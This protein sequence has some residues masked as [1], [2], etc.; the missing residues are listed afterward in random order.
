MTTTIIKA[1]VECDGSGVCPDL[2]VVMVV[3]VSICVSLGLEKKDICHLMILPGD[4]ALTL[5][6]Y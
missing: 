4:E 2:I 1:A 5:M 6:N 3:T